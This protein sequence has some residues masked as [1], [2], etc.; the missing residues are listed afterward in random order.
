MRRVEE[1]GEHRG[2]CVVGC[3]ACLL[4]QAGSAFNIIP[5]ECSLKGTIRAFSND[6]LRE[7]QL[8][9]R[10][11][12]QRTAE[13]FRCR[14]RV[15]KLLTSTPALYVNAEALA[16]LDQVRSCYYS[17]R[18]M[19][20][21]LCCRCCYFLSAADTLL[22]FLTFCCC[23]AVAAHDVLFPVLFAHAAAAYALW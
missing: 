16:I 21:L 13:A 17:S 2:A 7:L 14:L 18:D 6:R 12:V 8:R 9:L 1:Q 3:S 19:L 22:L 4:L 20:L 23:C 10:Q 11:V 15:R 5:S